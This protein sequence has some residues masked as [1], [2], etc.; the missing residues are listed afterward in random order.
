MLSEV[1]AGMSK[2]DGTPGLVELTFLRLC[3]TIAE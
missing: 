2:A 3:Q 1:D